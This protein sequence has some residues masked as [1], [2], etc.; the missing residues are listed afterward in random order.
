MAGIIESSPAHQNFSRYD[1]R[2]IIKFSVILGKD[3]S[4]IHK[5]QMTVLGE[6]APS[7]QT[8]RK[9][10]KA[11]SEGRDDME[12]EP[13]PGRPL[14]ACGDAN[15]SKVLVLLSDDRRKTCEEISTETSMYRTSMF[16]V[17]TNKLNNNK[18][19][20]KWTDFDEPRPEKVRR[21]QGALKVMHM[22]FQYMNGEILRWPVPIGTTIN[23]QYYKRVLQ[24]K[25]RPAIR[26]KRPGLLESGI[27]FHHDNAPV[28][29]AGAVTDVLAGY[30]WELLEIPRYS[31]DL[32]PCD[33]HLFPKMKEH[34]RGQR[35]ETEED[36]IQA[37]KV[38][39]KNLDKCSYVTAF[40]DWLQRIEK[41]ANNGGC[42]VE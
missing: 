24:D 34:L 19:F 23:A 14:T 20:S 22:I 15:I 21:K 27:L 25:L 13:R 36:I 42:Y 4:C 31:P 40:K 3:A 26:K 1:I 37:T 16:R 17:L 11:V 9:W 18:K 35:F 32:A 6:N 30:K 39:I 10:V 12:D 29:T 33:F 41:C 5:D 2:V 38:A 7:I 8:V 28:H